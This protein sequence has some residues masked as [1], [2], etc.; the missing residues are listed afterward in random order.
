MTQETIQQ[1]IAQLDVPQNV[2]AE[3]MAITPLNYTGM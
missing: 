3:L 1:F 2:K